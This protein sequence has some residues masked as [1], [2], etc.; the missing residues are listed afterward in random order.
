VSGVFGFGSFERRP[1]LT[2][3][4]RGLTELALWFELKA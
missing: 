1:N 3:E 2:V 4:D